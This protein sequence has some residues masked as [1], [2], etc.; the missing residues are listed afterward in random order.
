VHGTENYAQL[1]KAAQ[2]LCLSCHGP[3]SPNG[4]HTVSLEEHTHHK[5]GSAGSQCVACHMPKIASEGVPGSFVSSH[6]F[7]FI[8]PA[9][10]EKYQMPNACTSC[11]KDQNTAW[12][13]ASMRHWSQQSP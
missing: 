8:T 11:H 4:P 2:E 13:T 3:S 5:D 10:T 7:K 1:R 9:M 12:A 6:T